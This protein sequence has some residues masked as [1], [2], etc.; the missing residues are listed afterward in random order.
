MAVEEATMRQL[1][2]FLIMMLMACGGPGGEDPRPDGSRLDAG[3]V[4]ICAADGHC[5]D[6]LFCTGLERCMPGAEGAGA[7]G[8]VPGAAPCAADQICDEHAAR[9]VDDECTD[10]GD[11]DGDGDR[12]PA[13]GG[14]DCDDDN[15]GVNSNLDEMCDPAG[16]N[17]DCNPLTIQN[18]MT[19]DGDRDDDGYIDTR[20]FNLRDDGTENRGTDCDDTRPT[21]SPVGVEACDGIDNN[22]DGRVDEGVLSTFYFDLD[23]DNY[24]RSDMNVMACTRPDGYALVGGDCDDGE[25]PSAHSSSVNPGAMEVCN[26]RDDDCDGLTDPDCDCVNGATLPCGT[27]V[28][29]CELGTQTCVSGEWGPCLG[30][31]GPATEV[32]G[33]GDEDCDGLTDEPGASGERVFYRDADGDGYGN[34]SVTILAC[35]GA[36]GGPPSGYV[37]DDRDCADNRSEVHPGASYHDTPYCPQ[38][39]LCGTTP[40]TWHCA[41]RP[42]FC[43]TSVAG[44]TPSFD[45]NCSGTIEVQPQLHCGAAGACGQNGPRKPNV[46]ADCGRLVD[47]TACAREMFGTIGCDPSYPPD[48]RLPC[49]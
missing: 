40:A 44:V 17:E 39:L 3:A 19:R 33:G 45:W 10:G 28:G 42:S 8:C 13:C 24:G 47:W 21:V 46:A 34:P 41:Y 2:T 31:V 27:D 37:T 36:G 20:C 29:A 22:C 15:G 5:D 6:G 4:T 7:D 35:P 16:I 48:Q 18:E 9:C 11:A 38:Y 25:V 32:C 12:R 14:G 30:G 1:R 49:R 43:G 23:N 26:G